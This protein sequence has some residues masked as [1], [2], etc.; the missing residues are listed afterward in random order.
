MTSQTTSSIIITSR[1]LQSRR[2]FKEGSERRRGGKIQS[3]SVYF[4]YKPPNQSIKPTNNKNPST[5]TSLTNHTTSHPKQPNPNTTKMQLPTTLLRRSI[6][7][8]SFLPSITSTSTTI[9]R[10][11]SQ[12]LPSFAR[13]DTQDKDSLKPEPNEYSKSGS[14]DAAAATEK[15]AF[16]PSSTRPE[17]E[18]AIAG[19]ESGGDVSILFTYT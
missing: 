10:P 9:T 14:D 6:A 15:A 3:S 8:T 2:S 19:K 11:F 13:K 17:E 5:S 16:D 4:P 7:R 1:E 18:Q 12:T